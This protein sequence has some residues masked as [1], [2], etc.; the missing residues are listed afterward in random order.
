MEL[1]PR[2]SSRIIFNLNQSKKK[3][4]TWR[5]SPDLCFPVTKAVD[6]KHFKIYLQFSFVNFFFLYRSN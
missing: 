1:R 4:Q 2:I 5:S 3:S 6:R